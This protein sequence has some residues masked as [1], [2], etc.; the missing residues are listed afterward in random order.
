LASLGGI[1][2][3]DM[4][5]LSVRQPWAWLIVSG[6]TVENR[7]WSTAHRGALLIHAARSLVASEIDQVEQQ[8]GLRI[9]REEL[10]LGAIIGRVDLVDILREHPSPFF[11][12]PPYYAWLLANAAHLPPVA[13]RGQLRLFHAH[14][15]AIA[16]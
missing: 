14:H 11:K 4:K 12:G 13:W 7:T 16:E 3:L 6:L 10:A 2:C 15:P 9:V 1:E 5:T 8:F